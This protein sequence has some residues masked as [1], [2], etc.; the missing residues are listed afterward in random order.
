MSEPAI[1]LRLYE[2]SLLHCPD[3]LSGRKSVS[4]STVISLELDI[5]CIPVYSQQSWREGVS[6][7]HLQSNT[8]EVRGVSLYIACSVAVRA[9]CIPLQSPPPAVLM[10][11]THPFP[12]PAVWTAGCIQPTPSAVWTWW[13][14]PSSPPAVK[15]RRVYTYSTLNN[16]LNADAQL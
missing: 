14:S 2:E 15:K 13:V 7:F 16:G 3:W 9:G 10:C 1:S 12:P 5:R 11:S 4:L 8:V 6:L